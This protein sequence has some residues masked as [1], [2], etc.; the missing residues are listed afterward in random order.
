MSRPRPRPLPRPLPSLALAAGLVLSA[1]AALH[2]QSGQRFSLQV[3]PIAVL[4]F[5]DVY[6]GLDSGFGGEAQLR[7]TPGAPRRARRPPPQGG[8][9]PGS[10]GS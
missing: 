3:S 9:A 6:E 2:A 1:P 5:G 8:D 4:V 10:G 7:Y